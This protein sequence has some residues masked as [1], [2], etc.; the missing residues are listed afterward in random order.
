MSEKRKQE[1]SVWNAREKRGKREEMVEFSLL[2]REEATKEQVSAAWKER[3][4]FT[5]ES[6]VMDP[7]PFHHC[8]IPNFI[9]SQT[10]LEGLQNELLNLN[11][12]EKSNDL[13][14][15]KQS[16]DLKKRNEPHISA[17]RKVLFEDFRT[18]LSDITKVELEQT[19]D[20][21]CAK[22][23]YTDTL[24]C[25]DD[26]LEGRRI[27]F[28]L[29]LVPPW[30]KTDG[31]TLDLYSIDDHFQPQEIVKSLVPSWNSLAFFEVSPV[32][33][34][35]VSEILSEGKC[36]LSVSG[37]FHGPSLERP[38]RYIEPLLPRNP[39]IPHDHKILYEWISP[40]YLD[41]E[42]HVQVQEE[43]EER[44][45]IL[46]KN[47]LKLDKFKEVCET[48]EKENL[49]W[50]I[51]G[52]PNKR[53]YES[54]EGRLP[55][56]LRDCMELFQS[57]AMF[58]LLSNLTGLKLHFLA[59][60]DEEEDRE[61]EETEGIAAERTSD[62]AE[63]NST[64]LEQGE[65]SQENKDKDN[66]LNQYEQV[67]GTEQKDK[68]KPSGPVC[69]GELRHWGHGHYTLMHDTDAD[70]S[71]FALDLLLFCGCQDWEAEYGGFTSYI[72]KEEDEE[73]LT[74][75]PENNALALIYRDKETLKFVKYI[76]HRSLDQRESNLR[77]NGF[78]DFSFVYYE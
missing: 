53:C 7:H 43:F 29:Y 34:H 33:F 25:H 6:I 58:L 39:H 45:E 27:A 65:S 74:L 37:W 75:Y 5:H 16:D 24:L 63:Q 32:S 72:A 59:S 2:V 12:R 22:Y 69:N 60:D 38:T 78:W 21:S 41:M 11:F 23:N 51:R 70:H 20:M 4:A 47:F 10:F 57:E 13:Y 64:K 61:E 68:I 9:Q 42:L 66:Q 76:N 54:A 14:K 31:G 15:F 56:V 1:Q 49:K 67:S 28:I 36:R 55:D 18:W 50:K 19:V 40:V 71:E 77:R 3:R 17:L 48:L 73:L 30:D 52:P 62:C 8:V 35:Q 44:S 26:E 46:L